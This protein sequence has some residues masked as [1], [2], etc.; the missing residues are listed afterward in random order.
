VF[1]INFLTWHAASLVLLHLSCIYLLPALLKNY[2]LTASMSV[3]YLPDEVQL[4][5]RKKGTIADRNET[6]TRL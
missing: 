6:K 4:L 3:F 1:D 2:L 5:P